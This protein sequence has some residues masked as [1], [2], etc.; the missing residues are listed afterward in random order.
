M[1]AEGAYR[2]AV[3]GLFHRLA[4]AGSCRSHRAAAVNHS[5][6]AAAVVDLVRYF[7]NRLHWPVVRQ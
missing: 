2:L 1:E 6:P 4:A 3:A 7:R 5:L